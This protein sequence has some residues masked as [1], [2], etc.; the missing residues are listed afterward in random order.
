MG[1]II[2]LRRNILRA[3]ATRARRRRNYLK[4][5][6]ARPLKWFRIVLQNELWNR[7]RVGEAVCAD[8]DWVVMAKKSSLASNKRRCAPIRYFLNKMTVTITYKNGKSETKTDVE[9][10]TKKTNGDT[11]IVSAL[12][13]TFIPAEYNALIVITK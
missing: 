12:M 8:G 11:L 7:K 5:V 1:I 13:F 9:E 2:M 6:V 3:K 4:I 10:I